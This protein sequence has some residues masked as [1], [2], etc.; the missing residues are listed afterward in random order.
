MM[1]K[2]DDQSSNPVCSFYGKSQNEVRRLIAGPTV[3]ICDNCVYLA[4]EITSKDGA[5]NERA[6]YFSFEFIAKLLSPVAW[7]IEQLHVARK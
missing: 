2:E 1:T 5:L 3:F 7:L 4:L 6:A